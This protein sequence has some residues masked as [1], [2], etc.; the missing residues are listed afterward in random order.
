M[1]QLAGK[2][3]AL[4]GKF[5]LYHHQIHDLIIERGGRVTEFIGADTTHVVVGENPKDSRFKYIR[6]HHIIMG[7]EDL[8]IMLRAVDAGAELRT[9]RV[10]TTLV[11]NEA[12]G[13]W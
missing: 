1:S 4:A 10:Q 2:V 6:D 9:N 7:E 12:Y 5:S 11:E 13:T 8:E 3:F